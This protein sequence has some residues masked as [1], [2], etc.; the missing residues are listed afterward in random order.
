VV[1][2]LIGLPDSKSGEVATT[3]LVRRAFRGGVLVRKRARAAFRRCRSRRF[4]PSRLLWEK[5]PAHAGSPA[6]SATAPDLRGTAR[7]S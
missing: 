5:R 7:M 4:A 6:A 3:V 2:R 1:G